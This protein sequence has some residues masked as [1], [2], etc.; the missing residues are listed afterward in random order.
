[1]KL[2]ELRLKNNL[3]QEDIAL[4]LNIKRATYSNYE[5]EKTQPTL[6]ILIKMADLLHVSVDE[7]VGRENKNI[8][9]KGLLTDTEIMIIDI[10]K[11]LNPTKLEKLESYAMALYVTQD[12]ENEIKRKIKGE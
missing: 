7:L 4:K 5:N 10:M 12:D 8:I 9:D 6:D 2:K 1:M 11:H 3:R